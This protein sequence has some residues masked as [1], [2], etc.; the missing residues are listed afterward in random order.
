MS[1]TKNDVENPNF[2][3]LKANNRLRKVTRSF[4]KNESCA[5]C[6]G[7]N[8]TTVIR[9]LKTTQLQKKCLFV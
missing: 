8:A 7:W 6:A 2:R 9:L 4:D 1:I 3:I 5:T